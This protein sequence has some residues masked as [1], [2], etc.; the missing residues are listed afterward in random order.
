MAASESPVV[1]VR[2]P[3]ARSA[4]GSEE[5]VRVDGDDGRGG[6]G[7]P[8]PGGTGREVLPVGEV[9]PDHGQMAV[10]VVAADRPYGELPPGDGHFG[11]FS[12]D[13]QFLGGRLG[14]G[15]LARADAPGADPGA[16]AYAEGGHR[17]V[18]VAGCRPYRGDADR[19]G[20]AHTV[21]TAEPLP[22]LLADDGGGV[23]QLLAPGRGGEGDPVGR[24][25][26]DGRD[27]L[28]PEPGRQ[29]R[30]QP[31]QQRDEHDH[32]SHQREPPLGESQVPPCDV[33]PAPLPF[34][35]LVTT[36]L[37]VA[38]TVAA[39]GGRGHRARDGTPGVGGRNGN[40]AFRL[41]G[42]RPG[43]QSGAAE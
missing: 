6:G 3:A 15:D 30:Q 12:I 4:A 25:A 43:C 9:G 10:R 26:G 34:S 32:G 18:P 28:L 1:T 39:G 21:G 20:G 17:G 31:H 5:G 11:S 8:A 22:L 14:Q 29:S 33:H 40:S 19:F 36:R 13:A 41:T 2:V 27:V 42:P 35:G 24:E 16:G 7:P 23:R 38:S 37:P